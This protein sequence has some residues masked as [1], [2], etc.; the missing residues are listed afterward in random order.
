MNI[1]LTGSIAFDYLMT[2]PGYFKDNIL[3]DM[4]EKISLSFLVDSLTRRP[5]GIAANIGYTLALL[6]ERPRVMATVGS[7][8]EEQRSWLESHGVDTSAIRTIP[9]LLTAS[10][11]VTTDQANA[12]IA[13]FFPGAMARASELSLDN[14][15]PAPEVVVI[16]PN[17]PLAMSAYAQQAGELGCQIIY[18][19]SQQIVRL[20]AEDIRAGIEAAEALFCNDYEYGLIEEKTGLTIESILNNTAFVVITRGKQGATVDTPQGQVQVPSI[21]PQRIADPTG[22]G[23]AF[24]GG[25]LKGYLHQLDLSLC[26]QIGTLAATYCLEQDGPQGHHFTRKDFVDRF[27]LHFDDGGVLN[28][29]AES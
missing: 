4:I 13:S 19:P 23:D 8:F 25:F 21:P 5:G 1:V 7:D 12:Q 26:A 10:F 29:L 11:F 28:T 6:G 16:S 20:D 22:V 14:L 9:D 17:D 15:T 27:R 2:F 3:P 18:D 24:R